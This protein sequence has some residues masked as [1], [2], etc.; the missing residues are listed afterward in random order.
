MSSHHYEYFHVVLFLLAVQIFLAAPGYDSWSEDTSV[1]A[2]MKAFSCDCDEAGCKAPS[3]FLDLD[4]VIAYIIIICTL[5]IL[6]SEHF[7]DTVEQRL[8]LLFSVTMQIHIK[9]IVFL[10]LFHFH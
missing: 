7:R 6:F 3:H 2:G 9:R 1:A 10:H 5:L 4:A 8:H